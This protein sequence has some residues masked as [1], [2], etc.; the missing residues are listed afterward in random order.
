MSGPYRYLTEEDLR[1]L[2]RQRA[3]EELRRKLHSELLLI[4]QQGYSECEAFN[5]LLCKCAN[6]L[7]Q[8]KTIPES[9]ETKQIE[10]QIREIQDD[11]ERIK[12]QWDV[13]ARSG[14]Y[15]S[16]ELRQKAEKAKETVKK[17]KC[18]SIEQTAVIEKLNKKARQL[19]VAYYDQRLNSCT[20]RSAQQRPKTIE[21]KESDQRALD[22]AYKEK[23]NAEEKRLHSIIESLKERANNLDL[24]CKLLIE[25]EKSLLEL[26]QSS[27]PI[28]EK[29]KKLHSIDVRNIQVFEDHLE[30]AERD[31]TELDSKI[32]RELADYH[33]LCS[34][35]GI[36][37]Q[38]FP[39]EAASIDAIRKACNALLAQEEW[40]L[41]RRY[42]LGKIRSYLNEKGY[43]YI[44][45]KQEKTMFVR[46]VYRLGND[47]VF[48]IT[49]DEEGQV[50]IE[51]AKMDTV[52][53]QPRNDEIDEIVTA[54]HASCDEIE[55]M[56]DALNEMGMRNTPVFSYHGGAG[57]AQVINISEFSCEDIAETD[58]AVT[59]KYRSRK[60]KYK[61]LEA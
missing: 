56:F 59:R 3:E 48:H 36:E 38:E 45:E 9:E 47:M 29:V 12:K 10:H 49:F 22:N 16:D 27:I 60:M 14:G 34:E 4:I 20:A 24:D 58:R 52:D 53:R 33:A 44:G 43:V 15:T 54:Q 30:K 41:K 18:L 6:V 42:V 7:S 37:P 40:V 28:K 8:L 46:Q 51:I 21:E 17:I 61:H 35:L 11:V 39:F 23:Y 13:E 31:A 50:T 57:F 32:S 55:K 26:R 25:A 2:E 19:Q 5:V 1:E